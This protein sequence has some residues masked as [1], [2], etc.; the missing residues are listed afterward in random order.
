MWVR[1]QYTDVLFTENWSNV[2]ATVHVP[3]MNSSHK[4]EKMREKKKKKKKRKTQQLKRRKR[5]PKHTLSQKV[6][7]WTKAP[8]EAR[9]GD[10]WVDNLLGSGE[11]GLGRWWP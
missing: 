2:A 7:A 9:G 10:I 4:W 8:N 3:Y 6:L 1:E 11:L 5:E